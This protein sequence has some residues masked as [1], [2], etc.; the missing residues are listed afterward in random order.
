MCEYM[1][2]YLQRN[3]NFKKGHFRTGNIVSKIKNSLD[4]INNRLDAAEERT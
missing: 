3:G 2:E 4:G 1:G